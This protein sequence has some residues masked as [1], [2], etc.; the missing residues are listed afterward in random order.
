MTRQLTVRG[1][2]RR[3][4]IIQF[5]TRRFA[6][7]GFHPTSVTEIVEG[8][9]VGKGVFYWYFSSKEELFRAILRDAQTDLRHTQRDAIAG[10]E[11]PL[12]RIA[13]GIRSSIEWSKQHVDLVRLVAFA[14]TDDRFSPMIRKGEQI[15]IT[16]AKRHVEDA[17]AQ[18]LLRE[19]D[20]EMLT[21]AMLGVTTALTRQFLHSGG[22]STVEVARAAEQ[23]CLGGLKGAGLNTERS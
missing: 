8:I 3:S 18:G 9:G 10:L 19:S 21:Q 23:F 20:P 4:Q 5:A 6:E 17:I 7:K 13:A 2:L 15:A 1:E 16:D 14:A 12:D 22:R 11:D